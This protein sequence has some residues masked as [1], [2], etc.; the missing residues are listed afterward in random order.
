M[1]KEINRFKAKSDK[2]KGYIII[3]YQQYENT[4]TFDKPNDI[5]A[6]TTRFL[7]SDGEIV[8]KIPNTE[9]FQILLTN[10]IVRKVR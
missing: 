6:T 8:N 2:G 9:T 7:T 10:E 1:E 4:G 5:T 3:E